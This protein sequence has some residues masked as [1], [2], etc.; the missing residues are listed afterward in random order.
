M[1]KTVGKG[2]NIWENQGVKLLVVI[3]VFPILVLVFHQLLMVPSILVGALLVHFGGH[4]GFWGKT[5]SV[6]A[7]I[8]ACWGAVAVCKLIWHSSK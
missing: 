2:E 4:P 6:I 7:L 1:T 3:F 5:L 8:P